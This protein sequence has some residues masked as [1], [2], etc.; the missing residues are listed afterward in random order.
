MTTTPPR[1]SPRRLDAATDKVVCRKQRR[2]S[3]T[4]LS[5]LSFEGSM[6]SCLHTRALMLRTSRRVTPSGF[7][8]S[9]TRR[10]PCRSETSHRNEPS[11]QSRAH[12]DSRCARRRKAGRGDRGRR[13]VSTQEAADLLRVSRPTLV[14]LLDQGLLPFEQPGVSPRVPRAAVEE[15]RASRKHRRRVALD[16]LAETHE[17][18][19][20]RPRGRDPLTELVLLDACVLVPYNLSSLVTELSQRNNC[21]SPVVGPHLEEVER[22]LIAK[23]GRPRDK[24]AETP[25]RHA[26]GFPEAF[27]PRLAS[28]MEP[29][30][31]CDAKD[32]HVL[33]AAIASNAMT[34]VTTN[35]D[36][37]DG[38]SNRTTCHCPS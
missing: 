3:S 36:F 38:A 29:S 7:S 15:F 18:D 28:V 14:K 13:D 9:S 5:F 2:P 10:R 30:L 26:G 6:E 27:R 35:L 17:P 1:T 23:I 33:A 31:S 19:A 21:S 34:I 11:R 32:R 12:R 4:L 20:P 8:E 24:V 37:P 16:A 22:T 25:G